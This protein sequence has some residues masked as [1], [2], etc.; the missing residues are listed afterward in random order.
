[1]WDYPTVYLHPIFVV[2]WS[3][4]SL[5]KMKYMATDNAFSLHFLHWLKHHKCKRLLDPL[6]PTQ[7]WSSPPRWKQHKRSSGAQPPAAPRGRSALIDQRHQL[8][9]SDDSFSEIGRN[10]CSC[11]QLQNPADP[12]ELMRILIILSGHQMR[13]VVLGDDRVPCE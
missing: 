1:M 4:W 12:G 2:V 13:R 6:S 10:F 3:L 11:M 9:S 5:E 7:G 8:L